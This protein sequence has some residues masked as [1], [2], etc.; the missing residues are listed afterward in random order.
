MADLY[1]K[2]GGNKPFSRPREWREFPLPG[3]RSQLVPDFDPH[4]HAGSNFPT[5]KAS[6]DEFKIELLRMKTLD[7][8]SPPASPPAALKLPDLN[9]CRVN[10]SGVSNLFFCLVANPA[11]CPHVERS[12]TF[13]FCFHPDSS[14]FWSSAK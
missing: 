2:S 6:W 12:A 7:L 5:N 11:G 9:F 10:P 4:I 14:R 3:G 1:W 8:P 13:T